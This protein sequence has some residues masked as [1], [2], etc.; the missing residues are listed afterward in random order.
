MEQ[1]GGDAETPRVCNN[2][3]GIAEG[4]HVEVYESC[5]ICMIIASGFVAQNFKVVPG[6]LL[7][8]WDS[9]WDEYLN[10]EYRRKKE[11]FE[12]VV[13]SSSKLTLI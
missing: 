9:S 13:P 10:I 8:N 6:L 5:C 12:N 4:A 1:V 3:S 2:Q 7:F 11:K